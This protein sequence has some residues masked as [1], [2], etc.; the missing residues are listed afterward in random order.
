MHSISELKSALQKFIRRGMHK[1]A[2]AAANGLC[3]YIM[4]KD[5]SLW[6]TFWAR[7][8][9]IAT[10]DIGVAQYGTHRYLEKVKAEAAKDFFGA[11]EINSR[12]FR[13]ACLAAVFTLSH[14]PK[15][16]LTDN[17]YIYFE[18]RPLVSASYDRLYRFIESR[19]EYSLLELIASV[20]RQRNYEHAKLRDKDIYNAVKANIQD[21]YLLEEL[22]NI[23]A[24]HKARPCVLY[25]MHL[26]LLLIRP[27]TK[28]VIPKTEFVDVAALETLPDFVYD[29]HTRRGREIL[30]RGFEHFVRVSC[31]LENCHIPDP[32]YELLLEGF[33]TNSTLR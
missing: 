17:S 12:A 9:I 14:S 10:E 16:R 29:K 2:L 27:P 7:L 22:E 19:D 32:Y 15:S 3:D 31:V 6:E 20:H 11:T 4:M 30:G 1:E 23:W 8:H 33:S 26:A 28:P 25:L 24:A 13:S 18:K 21:G 5:V